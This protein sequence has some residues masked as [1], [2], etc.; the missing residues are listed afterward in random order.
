[1]FVWGMVFAWDTTSV[2][3]MGFVWG[4][5]SVWGRVCCLWKGSVVAV[6]VVADER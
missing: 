4:T 1:M 5:A 3:G 6:A 2:W